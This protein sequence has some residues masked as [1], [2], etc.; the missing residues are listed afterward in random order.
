M[1]TY[2][3]SHQS[4]LIK[5][6]CKKTIKIFSSGR[7]IKTTIVFEVKKICPKNFSQNGNS[8]SFLNA[9]F[10]KND[11]QILLFVSSSTLKMQEP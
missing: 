4:P 9:E 8:S 7:Q 6:T 1:S 10:V 2:H 5:L 11:F 3:P